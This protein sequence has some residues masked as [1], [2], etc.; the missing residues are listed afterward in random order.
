MLQLFRNRFATPAF[1][2]SN[3]EP[4]SDLRREIDRVFDSVM[5]EGAPVALNGSPRW[6]PPMDVEE[7]DDHV[8]L[9]VELPGVDPKDVSIN[10]ENGV[11][12]IS[13]EKKLEHESDPQQNG[14]TRMFECRYGRFE[15]S[16]TLP[17]Y[18]DADKVSAQYENGIL[19]LDLPKSVHSRR[20]R[21]EIGVANGQKQ[22]E[23]GELYTKD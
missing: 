4:W 3:L 8:R 20:K 7:Q 11:L 16:L 6:V 9:H 19:T 5:S 1:F 22:I 2:E 23:S 15:R 21:I 12:T 13:G 14:A 18:I 17:Q 10:V